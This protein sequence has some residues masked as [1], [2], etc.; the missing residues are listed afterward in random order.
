MPPRRSNSRRMSIKTQTFKRGDYQ[1]QPALCSIKTLKVIFRLRGS[2]MPR[3]LLTAMPAGAGAILLTTVFKS[4]LYIKDEN[5]SVL[6][7]PY[8]HQAS[9]QHQ[10]RDPG[11]HLHRCSLPLQIFAIAAGYGLVIRCQQAYQR[12]WEAHTE[13]R[14]SSLRTAH[15]PRAQQPTHDSSARSARAEQPAPVLQPPCLA[16]VLRPMVRAQVL[17]ILPSPPPMQV[18]T[19]WSRLSDVAIMCAASTSTAA[20]LSEHPPPSLSEHLPR[21]CVAF[22]HMTTSAKAMSDGAEFRKRFCHL[23]PSR[24]NPQPPAPPCACGPGDDEMTS[25]SRCRCSLLSAL[26]V[27]DLQKKEDLTMLTLRRTPRD[28]NPASHLQRVHAHV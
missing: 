28:P 10:R 17:I 3:L 14:V 11:M 19:M 22:D 21:R 2:V 24:P 7:H 26:M 4:W 16:R 1:H 5:T 27:Q 25:A 18:R 13:V 8:A 12:W 6:P 20:S 15:T 9:S 23:C